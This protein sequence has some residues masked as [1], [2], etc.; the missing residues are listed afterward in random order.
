MPK[1]GIFSGE[2]HH[3]KNE[4]QYDQWI[5]EVK[6]SWKMYGEVPVREAIIH[7]LKGKVA[8]TIHYLGHNST[9]LAMLNKLNTVYGAIV[10]YDMLMRKFYQV[11]QER[12]CL[13]LFDPH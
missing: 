13:C 2:P 6:E 12:V 11:T 8:Q 3:G 5:F 7:S 10:I 4:V 9:M 1:Y